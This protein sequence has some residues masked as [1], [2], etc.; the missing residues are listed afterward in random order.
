[1]VHE[2]LAELGR[3]VEPVS[4][5]GN[6]GAACAD[7]VHGRVVDTWR[8]CPM[9]LKRAG[10][11][12]EAPTGANDHPVAAPQMLGAAIVDRPLTLRD[13]RVLGPYPLDA[14]EVLLA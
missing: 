3:V 11:V 7:P 14:G 6:D 9:R 8:R 2:R 4:V 12:Q 1:M 5:S 10:D 13:R